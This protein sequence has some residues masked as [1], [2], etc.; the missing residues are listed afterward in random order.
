MGKRCSAPSRR[1]ED[2]ATALIRLLFSHSEVCATRMRNFV[3]FRNCEGWR[4]RGGEER[5]KRLLRG[6][7][8]SC[9][10]F[11]HLFLHP[12]LLYGIIIRSIH[13]RDAVASSS[14]KVLG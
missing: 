10:F 13:I 4:G 5:R 2:H 9:L 8:D 11:L 6:L 12:S 1:C 14:D 3:S 7:Y